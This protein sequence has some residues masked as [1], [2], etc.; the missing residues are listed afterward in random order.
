MKL[1]TRRDVLASALKKSG[2]DLAREV[3]GRLLRDVLGLIL[4]SLRL[5]GVLCLLRL[6][7]TPPLHK[8][9]TRQ[10][11]TT[12]DQGGHERIGHRV[13]H[14]SDRVGKRNRVTANFLP[15]ERE[16]L[17][18]A[19]ALYVA[20][21]YHA[22]ESFRETVL[23]DCLADGAAD[24]ASKRAS[25]NDEAGARRDLVVSKDGLDGDVALLK[26]HAEAGCEYD[27]IPDPVKGQR[28]TWVVNS[29]ISDNLPLGGSRV[30]FEQHE[31]CRAHR[32]K[33][34]TRK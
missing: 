21:G 10:S 28:R 24:Y 19:Y 15:E 4:R 1:S 3:C 7:H 2:S 25:K 6:L 20:T 31:S 13:V 33:H 32:H 34:R 26:R 11:Q 16:D 17:R 14:F 12:H 29:V 27:L 23:E 5:S 30:G 18:G 9:C 8:Q 22:A